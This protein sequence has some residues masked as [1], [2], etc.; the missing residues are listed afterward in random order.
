MDDNFREVNYSKPGEWTHDSC[1]RQFWWQNSRW[2][3]SFLSWIK[4]PTP[5]PAKACGQ[6]LRY[7]V[8]WQCGLLEPVDVGDM[9]KSCLHRSTMWAK[10][11]G[12]WNK[13]TENF[14]AGHGKAH[15]H[16]FI[17]PWWPRT[18]METHPCSGAHSWNKEEIKRFFGS[19]E[20]QGF[21]IHL[22]NKLQ[23]CQT[24][25]LIDPE[26]TLL[27]NERVNSNRFKFRS[28]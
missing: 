26:N 15:Q 11:D 27:A 2:H 3:P 23:K 22:Q 9:V 17:L 16:F 28:Q 20:T 12:G 18:K 19:G 10:L 25:P 14:K 4:W 21:K 1:L 5:A 24:G 6:L 7:G 8:G 13:S